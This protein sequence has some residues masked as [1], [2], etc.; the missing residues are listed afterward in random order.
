MANPV[1]PMAFGLIKKP[2]GFLDK[3]LRLSG[4]LWLRSPAGNP[5][6][7]GYRA[8]YRRGGVRQ[9]G[10]SQCRA[11]P[12]G[13]LDGALENGLGQHHGKL[14]ASIARDDVAVA[15]DALPHGVGHSP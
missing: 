15:A 7:Q 2:V 13:H 8:T 11:N 14:F 12:I 10:Q 4:A 1:A 5:D 9:S 6:A 3:F